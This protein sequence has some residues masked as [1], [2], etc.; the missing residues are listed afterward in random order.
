[1]KTVIVFNKIFIFVFLL[2][3]PMGC[4]FFKYKPA[5]NYND[6]PPYPSINLKEYKDVQERPDQEKEIAVAVAI[7]GGGHRAAN[8]AVGV[9][10][11]LEDIT[12]RNLT[13]NLLYEIDYFSTVSGGGFAAG[14]YIESLY[15]HQN[16]QKHQ[17]IASSQSFSFRNSIATNEE[18]ESRKKCLE[19]GYTHTL[20]T[21][22]IN[23]LIIGQ[24]DR[25]DLLESELDKK[26]LG[27]ERLGKSLTL[28]DIFIN[29]YERNREPAL[30][31]WISNA[32]IFQNGAIFP[33]VPN[34]LREYG[35]NGYFHNLKKIIKKDSELDKFEYTIPLAVGMKASASF[36]C[37]VPTSTL[38]TSK[39]GNSSCYLQLTDGG[40][41]DNLGVIT[42]LEILREANKVRK[43]NHNI[44]IVIDAFPSGIIPFS[45]EESSPGI[46]KTLYRILELNKDAFRQLMKKNAN[47]L[48]NSLVSGN[49]TDV[50]YLDIDDIPDAKEIKTDLNI[51]EEEQAFLFDIG[52]K[53]VIEKREDIMGILDKIDK[54]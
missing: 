11:G 16:S 24:R 19:R 18:Y 23:P 42:A 25:G 7:S 20:Y 13:N 33:F 3:F 54:N 31:I 26:I 15:Y 39:C 50:I 47:I 30:P 49:K 44:L 46:L 29:S 38:E 21:G 1:M 48:A 5:E 10:M 45:Q 4:T 22:I 2:F 40:L 27:S 14:V 35:V 17:K 12:H 53:L 43:I 32:T 37:A 36:P 8:L 34:V 51:T 9:L 52:E 41:S 28:G 6:I